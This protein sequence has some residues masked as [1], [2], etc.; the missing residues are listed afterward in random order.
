MVL[1]LSFTTSLQSQNEKFKALFVYNF[2]KNIDW[3]SSATQ[4]DFVIGILGN[5]PIYDELIEIAK[6]K[7]VVNQK[8]IVK[9]FQSESDL[10]SKPTLIITD[11]ATI[12]GSDINFFETDYELQFN[13]Y[14]GTIERKGLKVSKQLLQLSNNQ[15]K[16][17]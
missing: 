14:P 16:N 15:S 10:K 4:G 1:L 6:K 9:K 7:T 11:R 12:K 17:N 5:T 8:I 3:P 2:T 13:I